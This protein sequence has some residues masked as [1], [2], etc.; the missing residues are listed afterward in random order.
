ML[1]RPSKL[2]LTF[3][4][5]SRWDQELIYCLKTHA[6]KTH[7][8]INCGDTYLRRNLYSGLKSTAKQS[9][10]W[11]LKPW[12][13]QTSSNSFTSTHWSSL[14]IYKLIKCVLT[15]E[16]KRGNTNKFY[17]V[18]SEALKAEVWGKVTICQY[19][20]HFCCLCTGRFVHVAQ[21]YKE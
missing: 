14:Q 9:K 11:P 8:L 16:V 1:P 4:L 5:S 12:A 3:R 2:T 17:V 18:F 6:H 13:F 19:W 20:T 21:K 7:Y 15:T 10:P